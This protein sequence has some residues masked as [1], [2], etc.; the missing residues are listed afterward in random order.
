MLAY[1]GGLTSDQTTFVVILGLAVFVACVL[2][3]A[4]WKD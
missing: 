1:S 2:I 4:F 3:R